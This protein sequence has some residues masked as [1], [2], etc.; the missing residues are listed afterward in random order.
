MK[1][2]A[3]LR[4]VA[5]KAIPSYRNA[6]DME[7][8]LSATFIA[9]RSVATLGPNAQRIVAVMNVAEKLLLQCHP[10]FRYDE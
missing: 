10:Q 9:A 3:Y 6:D 7:E 4:S 8:E 5:A 2:P 1:F